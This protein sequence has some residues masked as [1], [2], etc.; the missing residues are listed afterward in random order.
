[1]LVR[2]L[3][4]TLDRNRPEPRLREYLRPGARRSH[5]PGC[6][7]HTQELPPAEV[8]K[9]LGIRKILA[10]YSLLDSP[11]SIVRAGLN[12]MIVAEGKKRAETI[13]NEINR[14]IDPVNNRHKDVKAATINDRLVAG[15]H[16]RTLSSSISPARV[17]IAAT[18]VN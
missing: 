7:T 5:S 18:M 13:K 15:L 17:A 2:D 10:K 9:V 16:V 6:H 12:N 1:M 14:I 4:S 11:P 3:R 8:G